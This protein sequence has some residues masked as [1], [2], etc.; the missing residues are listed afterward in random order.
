MSERMMNEEQ[1]LLKL[2]ELE[3]AEAQILDLM[4]LAEGTVDELKHVPETNEDILRELSQGYLRN[5]KS[6]QETL[7]KHAAVLDEKQDDKGTELTEDAM[8]GGFQQQ[9]QFSAETSNDCTDGNAN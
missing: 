4:A 7:K 2:K 8:N 6:V 3:K 9:Y 1:K 5:I